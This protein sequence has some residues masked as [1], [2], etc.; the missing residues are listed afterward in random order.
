MGPEEEAPRR[1]VRRSCGRRWRIVGEAVAVS[2]KVAA[3]A[4]A[5]YGAI[6][7]IGLADH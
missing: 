7:G 3:A 4:V 2:M 5:L 1:E 6:K